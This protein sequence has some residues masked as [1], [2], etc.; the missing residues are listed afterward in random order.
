[1]NGLDRILAEIAQDAKTAAEEKRSEAKAAAQR[2]IER[3]REEA[4]AIEADAA[5]RAELEYKRIVSRAHSTGEIAKKGVLLRE[6]QKIIDGILR[7]AHVKLAGLS[8]AEYFALMGRLLNK[9]ASGEQGEILLSKRDQQRVT[10]EFTQAAKE[11]NLTIS[12][13]T[14]DIDGGFILSYGSIEENCSIAALMESERD[15]L[16]DVVKAFLFGKV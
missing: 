10:A 14:R 5:E 7:D 3:A 6:K 16:H 11:K 15:R 9:Y 8:D 1:M 13:D 4:K 2:T 12:G